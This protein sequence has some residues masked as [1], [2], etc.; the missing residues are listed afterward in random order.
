MNNSFQRSKNYNPTLNKILQEKSYAHKIKANQGSTGSTL[1]NIPNFLAGTSTNAPIIDESNKYITQGLAKE[2][3]DGMEVSGNLKTKYIYTNE[4]KV[5]I[6]L[7]D[8]DENIRIYTNMEL[9]IN[10]SKNYIISFL[11]MIF[12]LITTYMATDFKKFY[13]SADTWKAIYIIVFI[14]CFAFLIHNLII[15]IKNITKNKSYQKTN[16]N[17][18]IKELVNHKLE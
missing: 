14:I 1:D 6:C 4:D 5:R 13:F 7:R 3:I 16:E 8:H 15:F 10:Q 11:A 2:V 18:F 17:E 9:N 12:T